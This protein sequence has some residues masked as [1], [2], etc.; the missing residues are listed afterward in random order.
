MICCALIRNDYKSYLLDTKGRHYHK[1]Q[2]DIKM[3]LK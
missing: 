2:G 3:N 1:L